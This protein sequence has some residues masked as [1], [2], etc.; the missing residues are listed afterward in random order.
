MHPLLQQ[1]QFSLLGRLRTKVFTRISGS[2]ERLP[3][4]R[5]L[6]R[7]HMTEWKL[8]PI[9]GRIYFHLLHVESAQRVSFKS[10]LSRQEVRATLRH[11]AG[12][13]A[14]LRQY[15]EGEIQFA[16]WKKQVGCL[17]LG[18]T[19][20][21]GEPGYYA[22]I[23]SE[24]AFPSCGF[25]SIAPSLSLG[26][27]V[28]S[29]L[30]ADGWHDLSF[31]EAGR[32]DATRIALTALNE[33]RDSRGR[34]RV[35]ADSIKIRPEDEPPGDPE[36]TRRLNLVLRGRMPLTKATVP[37]S[38]VRLFDPGFSLK[39]D[40]RLICAFADNMA[41]HPSEMLVYWDGSH[42]IASDDYYLYAAYKTLSAASLPVVIM[43]DFPD[44]LARVASRG[45]QEF[46]PPVGISRERVMPGVTQ[47]LLRLS[48][49]RGGSASQAT[50][51]AVRSHGKLDYVC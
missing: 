25:V 17:L 7:M 10:R 50:S 26:H 16:P 49:S 4:A 43:G 6:W 31:A 29:E 24:E 18:H 41:S 14:P 36:C 8:N 9:S 13:Q 42:F 39:L 12:H 46:L 21:S 34:I 20:P 15:V 45:G 37:P 2:D 11:V 44:D 40:E 3:T 35:P 30:H 38:C 47:D 33:V 48:C 23:L 19:R 22:A 51:T 28:I 1:H 5:E 27:S 32:G